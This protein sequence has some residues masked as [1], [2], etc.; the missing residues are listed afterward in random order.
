MM[1]FGAKSK[2]RIEAVDSTVTIPSRSFSSKM[3]ISGNP[4]LS[5]LERKCNLTVL[6]VDLENLKLLLFVEL[7]DLFRI[8]A[9]VIAHFRDMHERFYGRAELYERTKRRDTSNFTLDDVAF[10]ELLDVV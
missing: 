3:R 2:R 8:D 10:F 7:E 6:D 4:L 9:F 5:I 1:Q